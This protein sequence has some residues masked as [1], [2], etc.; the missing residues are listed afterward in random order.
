MV[1]F[2]NTNVLLDCPCVCISRTCTMVE[3]LVVV[4]AHLHWY[5]FEADILLAQRH[6]DLATIPPAIV[7]AVHCQETGPKPR[8]HAG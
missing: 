6:P 8:E 3:P 5:S 2:C 4:E 7:L 1:A